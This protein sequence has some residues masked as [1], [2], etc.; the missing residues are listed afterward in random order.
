MITNKIYFSPQ[1][2]DFSVFYL[3]YLKQKVKLHRLRLFNFEN[4]DNEL[5]PF[6]LELDG[7]QLDGKVFLFF[8]INWK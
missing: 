2:I 4:S 1:W 6:D 3:T 7:W 8:I 5:L